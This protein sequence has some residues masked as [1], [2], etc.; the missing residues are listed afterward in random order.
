MNGKEAVK[1]YR[2][3]TFFEVKEKDSI[4][5]KYYEARTLKGQLNYFL[6][7]KDIS[8]KVLSERLGIEAKQMSRYSS[9][10]RT[11]DRLTVIRIGFGLDLDVEDIN[12]L[13]SSAG[14]ADLSMKR[15]EDTLILEHFDEIKLNVKMQDKKIN[16]EYYNYFDEI[17]NEA[18]C[19]K[20]FDVKE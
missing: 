6:K 2:E 5:N 15:K 14:F 11:P 7:K 8:I 12:R 9:G 17:L 10:D 16:Y 4:E 20:L 3:T 1:F 18:G 19:G 13:L